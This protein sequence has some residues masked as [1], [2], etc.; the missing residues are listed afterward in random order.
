MAQ[1]NLLFEIGV[2][3][4]PAINLNSFSEKIKINIERKLEK[5]G[6][7]YSS[8]SN[9]YTNIR[10]IFLVKNVDDKI[11]LE[12]KLIK[13]P[14]ADK[15][16][17]KANKPTKTGL[18]FAN[19]YE[20]EFNSLIKKEV[21]GKEYLFYERP[22]TNIKAENL[23]RKILEESVS[24]VEDQKKMRWGNSNFSFIRPIRWILLIFGN[25][26]ISSE[27]LGIKT[28]KYTYGSKLIANNKISIRNIDDYFS[29]LKSENIE[30]DQEIRKSIIEKDIK[31]ILIEKEHDEK[32]DCNLINELA[33]M[34]EFPYI[35]QGK[36][37]KKYLDLPDEV[38]KY[39]IQDTQKYFLLYK[40]ERITNSFIGVSN[41]KI[42]EKIIKGNERVINPRLDDAQ[43]FINKDLSNNLFE[44]NDYLKKIIFHKKL[45]NM[46]DKVQ[47]ISELSTY[48]NEQSYS[49]KKLLHKEIS[50]ICKL[51]LISNMVVEIPKLQGYMGSYY[52]LK[53]GI[54]SIVANGIK[55]HYAPRN[56]GDDIPIS[57]DA[58]IVAMADK[59]D[60][61][62]GAFLANE[63]PT[64]TRDPLGIRRA[65]N[66]MIRIMLKT[67]YDINLTKLINKASK[68]IFS[69]LHDLK[70]NEGTLLD[71][72]K[73]FKEKLALAYKEEYGY[74]ENLIRSI[75]N[76]HSD[77]NPYDMLKK[78]KAVNTIL[79][80]NDYK[81]LFEN[82]KRVANLLKK[83][84]IHL[85]SEI[86]ENL[87]R[88]S[89]EKILYNR[90]NDIRGGLKLSLEESDYIEYIKKLNTLNTFITTFFEEVMINV[91]EEDIKLN[92]LSLLAL[93]NN[94]YNNIAN[95]EILSP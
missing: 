17:D 60:T 11:V 49:D 6:I 73:F 92:R 77:L 79:A 14:P 50:D 41:V 20:V 28:N 62:V 21:Q 36:F 30:I 85:T 74:E 23:L 7:I 48:I 66:G 16:Y 90:I 8:L 18:G 26:H 95:I 75:I 87:L 38:L 35:Y 31:K 24:E 70:R 27:I 89:S 19:K 3:D 39:V 12:R 56:P 2:E 67:N 78:I 81:E 52:A 59:L 34:V 53:M 22:K 58:Q 83:S 37:P 63:K 29:T 71:C 9:Y 45:G 10:L 76:N 33:N 54:N 5:N 91:D 40:N 44:R 80:N 15:C 94:Y 64:G 93:I 32:I 72:H 61:I 4:L 86:D 69:K 68:I 88:E 65:T 82:A 47:R 13:G 25:K 1:K 51:D 57:V 84:S 43:F 55:D 42:N 46:F